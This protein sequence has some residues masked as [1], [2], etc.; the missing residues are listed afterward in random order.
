MLDRQSV[1]R[2]CSTFVDL[3]KPLKITRTVI[4]ESVITVSEVRPELT[5]A[6]LI[7]LGII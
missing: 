1:S 4:K 5:S 6:F 7:L 2:R 3:Q